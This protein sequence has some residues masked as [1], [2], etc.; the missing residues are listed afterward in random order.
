MGK[1]IIQQNEGIDHIITVPDGVIH[2]DSPNGGK[3]DLDKPIL[4]VSME[5]DPEKEI[6]SETSESIVSRATV[7][8]TSFI[9]P[10]PESSGDMVKHTPENSGS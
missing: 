1:I 4:I 3:L 7:A 10:T 5:G 6:D 8:I 2:I 9:H